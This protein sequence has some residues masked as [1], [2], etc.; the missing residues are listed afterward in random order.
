MKVAEVFQSIQGEG[1]LAGV[2]SSFIRASG[3]NLRC[4]W[5]D[6]PYASWDPEGDDWAVEKLVD[7]ARSG[8]RHVVFTGGE[9]MIQTQASTLCAALRFAGR[10][11]TVETAGTIFKPVE[12]DLLSLSPKLANSTPTDRDGG[13]FARAHEKLRLQPKAMNE[14]IDHTRNQ[15]GDVQIKFV[16]EQP[17]D[18]EE[19]DTVLSSLRGWKV[20]DV[21]LM[22]EGTD[23]TTLHERSVW[24]AQLC[25]D[26]GFR[27]CPRLHVDLF[28]NTRG[29]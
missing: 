20:D 29:T 13:R 2:P 5:C 7:W 19:I 3:C 4:T 10:H 11:V 15:G 12:I 1:K 9:P 28:G 23:T 25:V 14:L 22:P 17:G 8:P 24:L 21:L 27:Y 26:R 18:L 16:V 6:T